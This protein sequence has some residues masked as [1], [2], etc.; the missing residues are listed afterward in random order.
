MVQ[1]NAV[2]YRVR[3]AGIVSCMGKLPLEAGSQDAKL[4]SRT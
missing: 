1:A 4:A 2:Y 3:H